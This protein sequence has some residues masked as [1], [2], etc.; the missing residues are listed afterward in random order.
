MVTRLVSGIVVILFTGLGC[1]NMFMNGGETHTG[2]PVNY[3]AAYVVSGCTVK[4]S[5]Q[6][7]LG[8]VER[9]YLSEDR[10]SPVLY[11]LD[12]SGEGVVIRNGWLDNDGTH[13]FAWV[14]GGPGYLFSFW[15]DPAIPPLRRVFLAR[16]FEVVKDEQGRTRPKG[17]PIGDCVMRAVN[18]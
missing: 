8:P 14:S 6:K 11:E 7:M 9:F 10:G 3:Q 15:K 12:Y 13:F 17:D 16:T 2:V 18:K 4:S 1:A 5:G